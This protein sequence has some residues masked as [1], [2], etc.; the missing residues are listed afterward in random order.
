MLDF[1][2]YF[3]RVL[4]S[5]ISLLQTLNVVFMLDLHSFFGI[6]WMLVTVS[7]WSIAT[8]RFIQSRNHTGIRVVSL[9]T[10]FAHTLSPHSRRTPC[11]LWFPSLSTNSMQSKFHIPTVSIPPRCLVDSPRS[12]FGWGY[13]LAQTPSW[14]LP[15]VDLLPWMWHTWGLHGQQG[16]RHSWVWWVALIFI[17]WSPSWG[18]I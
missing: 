11:T 14:K 3:I 15:W 10:D 2:I 16:Y 4:L 12:I 17:I 5:T 9:S 8:V 6:T 7:R 13:G 1:I 18:W